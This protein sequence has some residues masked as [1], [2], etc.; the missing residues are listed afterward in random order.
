MW[1][2]WRSRVKHHFKRG[3]GKI[4]TQVDWKKTH[5]PIVFHENMPDAN[6]QLPDCPNK[7]KKT[8][9]QPN[10][11]NTLRVKSGSPPVL[12]LFGQTTKMSPGCTYAPS[13]KPVDKI[14]APNSY[15]A[16]A[17]TTMGGLDPPFLAEPGVKSTGSFVGMFDCCLQG[18]QPCEWKGNGHQW[19]GYQVFR[20]LGLTK[21]KRRSEIS[22]RDLQKPFGEFKTVISLQD[23]KY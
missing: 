15:C 17:I 14:T 19:L 16:N 3:N 13:N 4:S 7:D 10:Q 1:R 22:G 11:R 8:A 2:F 9:V 12:A 23:D 20:W 5:N 6:T 18:I 21:E